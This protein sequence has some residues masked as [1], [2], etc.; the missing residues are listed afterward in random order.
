MRTER[1][2]FPRNRISV[3]FSRS[4]SEAWL[5][6]T[7]SAFWRIVEL[8]CL[9]TIPGV[10]DRVVFFASSNGRSSGSVLPTSTLI[11]LLRRYATKKSIATGDD[12]LGLLAN[13]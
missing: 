10:L 11:F 6:Q 2:T 8:G 3:Q 13:R 9:P 4:K 12:I 1:G 5:R 7:F